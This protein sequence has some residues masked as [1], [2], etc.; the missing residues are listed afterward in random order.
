M[1]IAILLAAGDGKRLNGEIPKQ[2]IK[3]KDKPLFVYPLLKLL[4]SNLIDRI[5]IVTKAEYRNDVIS[6]TKSLNPTKTIEVING[7]NTR[8]DSVYN[9]LKL[10][11]KESIESNTNIL[12]HDSARIFLNDDLITESLSSINKH[13]A[14]TVAIKSADT[15]ADINETKINNIIN[16]TKTYKLQTPQTF[17][18]STILKAHEVAK[19]KNLSN[20]TDDTSLVLDIGEDVFIIP[21][22]EKNFKITTQIDLKLAEFL[23]Q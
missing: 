17:K 11:K 14:V 15:L 7:G 20:Y 13:N 10:L 9:A 21:G 5:I 12:I 3:I 23:L 8:Q 4:S 18:F 19:E 2:F 1:N 6:I 16:R 22:D